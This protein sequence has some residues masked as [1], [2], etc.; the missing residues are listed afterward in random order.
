MINLN[1]FLWFCI[2]CF[3]EHK[4]EIFWFKI[5]TWEQLLQF[6]VESVNN[7]QPLSVSGECGCVLCS[8]LNVKVNEV[9]NTFDRTYTC[10]C[11]SFFFIWISWSH[12]YVDSQGNVLFVNK[13]PSVKDWKIFS[14]NSLVKNSKWSMYFTK[15]FIENQLLIALARKQKYAVSKF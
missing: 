10:K 3:F 6:A 5:F 15:K 14:I 8:T 1:Y 7:T 4:Y 2:M 11:K 9:H 13:I 12:L